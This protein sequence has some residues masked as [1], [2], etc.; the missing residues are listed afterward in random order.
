MTTNRQREDAYA[1][2]LRFRSDNVLDQMLIAVV[3]AHGAR[4]LGKADAS[5]MVRDARILADAYAAEM[6]RSKQEV[7]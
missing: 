3:I 4:S 6:I 1:A 5:W 2:D 7:T